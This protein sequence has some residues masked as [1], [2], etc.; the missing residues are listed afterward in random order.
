[1]SEINL[2]PVDLSANSDSNK[3]AEL[4]KKITL[5]LGGIFLFVALLS[6]GII[7]LYSNQVQASNARQVALKKQIQSQESTEQK[8]FLVKDRID[9]IK[10][11]QADKNVEA[12]FEPL[13]QQLSTLPENVF[14][15][16]IQ[17]NTSKTQFSVLSKDSLGMEIFINSLVTSGLY[18]NLTLNN[19]FFSPDS[20]YTITLTVS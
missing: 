6:V 9:K 13:N 18:T 14:V 2:L 7:I 16:D 10:L 8:L 20:G 15:T 19:F 4:I 17:I 12:A 11:A 3:F 1:M 5:I